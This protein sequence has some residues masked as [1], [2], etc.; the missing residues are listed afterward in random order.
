MRRASLGA[1]FLAC[2]LVVGACHSS[3]SKAEL[4]KLERITLGPSK[5]SRTVGEMQ[6]FTA[7][8]HYADG[9]SRNITQRLDYQSSD[10]TIA[11]ANNA[12]PDRS[13]VDAL[14]PGRVTIT[15][16][17]PK[18]GVSTHATG[19]DATLTVVG[20]LERIMLAPSMITRPIGQT[21]R[22]TA[23]AY[24]AGGGTRNVTQ[25]LEYRTSNAEVAAVSNDKGDKSRVELRGTGS[26]TISAVD[27]VSGVTSSM[28]GGDA[29]VTVM[30]PRLP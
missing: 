7:M 18:T 5:A 4:G 29:T 26:A 3:A 9:T 22:L 8:G 15:A 30:P 17:D 19:D 27:P 14:A 1:S 10:P 25:R 11:K 6:H 16:T 28:S 24:Y 23:T 13:R 21:Q 20:K 12:K 2:F